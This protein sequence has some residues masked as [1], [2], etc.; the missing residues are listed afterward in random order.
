MRR[1]NARTLMYRSRP[2]FPGRPRCSSAQRLQWTR[3]MS[4][5]IGTWR[6]PMTRKRP[7][8]RRRVWRLYQC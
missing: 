6:E 2:M 7:A 3:M 1:F 5:R 4:E 8:G